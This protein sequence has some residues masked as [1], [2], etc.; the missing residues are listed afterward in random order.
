MRVLVA[1]DRSYLG[2]VIVPFLQQA[3]HDVVGLNAGW[4]DGND[5][6]SPP[7]GYE[8]STGDIRFVSP[9]IS[10]VWI[11]SSISQRYP[12]IRWVT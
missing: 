2:A 10:P 8:Q 4:Y 5:F 1:G 12:T 9:T 7:A 6:G 3:G 11:R